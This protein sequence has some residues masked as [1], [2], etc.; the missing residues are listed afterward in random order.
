[1]RLLDR[2]ILRELLRSGLLTT[3]VLVTVIA[4]GAAIK[5]LSDD[6]LFG[7]GQV[8]TYIALAM[9]PMLQF[10]IPFAAGF[11]GTLSL[12]RMVQDN[13]VLAAAAG[14]IPYRRVL[15]PVAGLGLALTL[16][17][18]VLTQFVIPQFWGLLER[19]IAKDVT[20]LFERTIESGE[21]FV[22]GDLQVW[23]DRVVRETDPPDGVDARL[24]LE[25]VAVAD[26]D[27]DGSVATDVTA[28]RVALDVY[29]LPDE[30]VL[31]LGMAN[32]VAFRPSQGMLAWMERPEAARIRIPTRLRDSPKRM[33]LPELGELLK[34]PDANARIRVPRRELAEMLRIRDAAGEIGRR[35]TETGAA[36]LSGQT[37]DRLSIE[38]AVVNGMQIRPAPGGSGRFIVRQ[39]DGGRERRVFLARS[40]RLTEFVGGGIG[41]VASGL[42][43]GDRERSDDLR[44]AISLTDVQWYDS[45]RPDD[46]IDRD[47]VTME[48]LILGDFD[49]RARLGASSAELIAAAE[50][51]GGS[52][53]NAAGR[54]ADRI[55]HLEREIRAR[56]MS[57]F[58]TSA[59]AMLLVV[60]GATFAMWRRGDTPL[61][62]YLLAFLPSVLDLI[63]IS[64][65]EHMVRDGAIMGG[66]VV[67]WTGNAVLVGLVAFAYRILARN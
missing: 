9:V 19:T 46:L 32:A 35:L 30:T 16:L 10:A 2:L 65:G 24:Y 26:L 8:A 36:E 61:N 27:A 44:L 39:F 6:D 66:T 57:R 31:S 63:L 1:M 14:G 59:T 21:P 38:G 48:G 33:T 17:M 47:E 25:N 50:A 5:P 29:R 49:D 41:A 54:L 11:A 12:H 20:I 15:M 60:L 52:V 64:A 56:R 22:L 45:G 3:G 37:V 4:F 53:A 28:N 23:A 18:V 67:M 58:A 34:N 51:M 7:A 43:V 40:A 62:I 55:E 13:E 42:T